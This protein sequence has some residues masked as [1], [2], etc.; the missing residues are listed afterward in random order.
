VRAGLVDLAY[1][2][3]AVLFVL[4]LKGLSHPRRAVRGNALGSLGMFLAVSVTLFDARIVR[5]DLI[6]AGVGAGTVL[7]A[8]LA[9]RVRMTG[10]P[11][12]VALFN[13]LGGGASALVAGSAMLS[14]PPANEIAAASVASGLVGAVTFSGS[15]VA[16]A[17]LQEWLSDWSVSVYLQRGLVLFFAALAAGAGVAVFS[18][19]R[20][21]LA[22]ALLVL[23]S[24]LLG[25]ALVTPIGGADM[26]VV[27]AF[28]NALSGLAAAATGFVLMNQALIVSGSLVGASGLILTAIMCRAMNRTLA[29]VLFSPPPR[30]SG[31]AQA[32]GS[33][34]PVKSASPEEVAM[35]LEAARRVVIVP[36]YG[37]AVAQAQHAVAALAQKLT[38]GGKNVDFAVHPVAGRMPGHMNV[39]LAEADVPYERLKDL[40]AINPDFA[41]T[42]VALVVG[43]NDVV[44][45]AARTDRESPI[46]GMP[47]LDVDKATTVIV[48]KRSM[49]PGFAGIENEL[50]VAGN[51]VMLFGDARDSVLALTEALG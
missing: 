5:L 42:D 38:G 4:A 14:S 32:F 47:I 28:L 1:L 33:D 3:T 48:L 39:L 15:V 16:M 49:R 10:M 50:F 29:N 9:W 30:G 51:T 44:N 34:G 20:G 25:I 2:A 19:P 24:L 36:G 27:I 45:P 13:G 23:L 43:A 35:I 12:L 37:M 41:A 31:R 46:F 22:Y 18:S 8:L 26:P 11:Q 6:L 7:G 40:D 17:K 21:V